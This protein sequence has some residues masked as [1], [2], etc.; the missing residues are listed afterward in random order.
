MYIRV[1]IFYNYLVFRIIV[2]MITLMC[3]KF[4]NKHTG[5]VHADLKGQRTKNTIDEHN[6]IDQKFVLLIPLFMIICLV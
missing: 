5:T 4:A 1:L 3:L 2:M 6:F